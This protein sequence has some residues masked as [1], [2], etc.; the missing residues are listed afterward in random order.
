M[1]NYSEL[2]T[3]VL[4]R[5][6]SVGSSSVGQVAEDGLEAAMCYIAQHMLLPDLRGSGTYTWQ[7][8]DT[9]VALGAGGL[10]VLSDYETPIEAW[11]HA[12][13]EDG[14]RYEYIEYLAF[15]RL[16]NVSFRSPRDRTLSTPSGINE[17]PDRAFTI[18][19]SDELVFYP[20]PAE[21][22]IITFY[23]EKA[24]AAYSDSGIPE[25]PAK[26]HTLLVDGAEIF[27]RS[28]Q[29]EEFV[30]TKA[31]FRSLEPQLQKFEQSLHSRRRH[32][33]MRVSSK[34]S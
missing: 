29:K 30:D 2:K 23:Y 28:Y 17:L 5:V 11:V 15:R 3:K 1:A 34:Y 21:G 19:D 26:W 10:N 20:T 13:G 6:D 7:S 8:G 12:S 4:R 33:S 18:N 25:I 31:L 24:P 27:V 9:S 32:S 14:L 16:K 22:S